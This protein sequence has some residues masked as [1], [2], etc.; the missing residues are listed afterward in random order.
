MRRGALLVAALVLVAALAPAARSAAWADV[1]PG[2]DGAAAR[3]P[4]QPPV[5]G[6]IVGRFRVGRDP[7][8]AGQR[9]GID[10][11]AAPG[12]T[13]RAPCGGRVAFAGR[14]PERGGAVSLRCGATTATVLGL[15][16]L[17]IRAGDVVRRG[18]RLGD[19]GP[20]GRLRLGA[21]WTARRF[22]YRDPM[23]LLGRAVG[24]TGPAPLGFVRRRPARGPRGPV[25]PVAPTAVQAPEAVPTFVRG[26][27]RRPARRLVPQ[28][29]PAPPHPTVPL[30]A[31]LGLGLL[32]ATLPA[33]AWRVRAR[34]GRRARRTAAVA[35]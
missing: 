15:E 33:G 23:T 22:G 17:G 5:D 34:G 21:R 32:A 11:A 4:W 13:V 25:A 3:A 9:R 19:A 1:A 10:L 28:A 14:L 35:E 18:D 6:P 31:W 2:A 27:A 8:A 12:A 26:D 30:A 7:F 29:V 16:A 24:R 20:T